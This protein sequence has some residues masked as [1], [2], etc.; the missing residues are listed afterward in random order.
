MIWRVSPGVTVQLSEFLLV[1]SVK[2]FFQPSFFVC[3]AVLRSH[4]DGEKAV[5]WYNPLR[6]GFIGVVLTS[7][8]VNFYVLRIRS[9]LQLNVRLTVNPRNQL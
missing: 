5:D 3:Y 9:A 4:N 7:C 8:K 2:V 1:T 6:L